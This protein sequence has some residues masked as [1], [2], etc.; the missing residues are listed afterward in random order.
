MER[1]NT[2]SKVGGDQTSGQ[3]GTLPRRHMLPML[4]SGERL[5]RASANI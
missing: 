4:L 1:T 3:V 2:G 5:D